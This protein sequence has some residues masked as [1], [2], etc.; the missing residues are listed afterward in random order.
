MDKT[1]LD[2]APDDIMEEPSIFL[3]YDYIEKKTDTMESTGRSAILPDLL[4][5]GRKASQWNPPIQRGKAF[6]KHHI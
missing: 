5:W 6:L 1:S 4:Y 2:E 3:A